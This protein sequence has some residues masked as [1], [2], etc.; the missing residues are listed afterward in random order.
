M[1]MKHW[2]NRKSV[3]GV[4][5]GLLISTGGLVAAEFKLISDVVYL[6]AEREEKLDVYLPEGADDEIPVVLYIHGGG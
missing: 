5:C 2:I 1:K 4:L 3:V 6:A